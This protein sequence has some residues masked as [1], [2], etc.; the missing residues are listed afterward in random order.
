M[1][2]PV[3]L[4]DPRQAMRWPGEKQATD[5][6]GRAPAEFTHSILAARR[7]GGPFFAGPVGAPSAGVAAAVLD[8][9]ASAGN[10]AVAKARQGGPVP[11]EPAMPADTLVARPA[12]DGAGRA[13]AQPGAPASAAGTTQP[14]AGA[15][16][17]SQSPAMAGKGRGSARNAPAKGGGALARPAAATPEAIQQQAVAVAQAIPQPPTPAP[18]NVPASPQRRAAPRRQ[19]QQ[20]LAGPAPV[21]TVKPPHATIEDPIPDA[22]KQ[23]ETAANAMLPEQVLPAVDASPGGHMPDLVSTPLSFEK[24]RMV[25]LGEQAMNDA[26]LD[27]KEKAELLAIRDKIIAPPK[28][29][30][31]PAAP[32]IPP[33][34]K[35]ASDPLPPSEPTLAERDMFTAVLARLLADPA[36]QA[37]DILDAAKTDLPDYPGTVLLA[38]KDFPALAKLGEVQLPTIE[39][40]LTGAVQPLAQLLGVAGQTLDTAVTARRQLLTEAQKQGVDAAQLSAEQATAAAAANAAAR[41]ADA[42]AAKTVAKDAE[43]RAKDAKHAPKPGFRALAEAAVARIQ[44]K[45]GEGIARIQLQEKE[46]K[47][48]LDRACNRQIAAY[49]AAAMADELAATQANAADATSSN[50]DTARAAKNRTSRAISAA[51]KWAA[52]RIEPLKLRIDQLKVDARAEAAKMITAVQDQGAAAYRALHAWGDAQDG[53]AQS[54][55]QDNARNLDTWANAARDTATTWASAQAHLA[56]LELQRDLQRVRE[57]VNDKMAADAQHGEQYQALTEDRRRD[58]VEQVITDPQQQDSVLGGLAAGFA[59]RLTEAERAPLKPVIDSELSALPIG[60]WAAR[61]Y[62]AKAR[63]PGFNAAEKSDAIY[64]AGAG[65]WGTDNDIIFANLKGLSKLELAAVEGHYQAN[66]KTTLTEAMGSELSGDHKERAL[67]LLQGKGGEAAAEAIHD[68]VW[69]PGT[70]EAQIM[71]ALRGLSKEERDAA[72]RYY[73]EK[74]KESLSA[75]LDEDLGDAQALQAQAL[76]AGKTDEADA[77]ALDDAFRFGWGEADTADVSKVYDQVRAEVMA[78]AEGKGWTAAE[79]EA[80]VLRRNEEIESAFNDKLGNVRQYSN[81]RKRS[82]FANAVSSS[83]HTPQERNF[84]KTLAANDLAS[85]DAARMEIERQGGYADDA[86]L[87]GVI[88]TQMDRAMQATRLDRGPQLAAGVSRQ[89]KREMD[90]DRAAGR[91]WTEEQRLD[92]QAELERKNNETIQ[93]EAFDRA[94]HSSVVLDSALKHDYGTNLASMIADNMSGGDKRE[95]QAKLDLIQKDVKGDDAKA[96]R[97]LDWAY[98]RIRYSIEGAGTDMPQLKAG[99]NGLTK[100]DIDKIN[101]RWKRDHHDETLE[102]AVEGDTSGREEGDLVDTVR[103]G[104]AETVSQKIN[105]LKRKKQRDDA[106]STFIGRW[107]SDDARAR[108][109]ADLAQLEDML[110]DLRDPNLPESRRAHIGA[111][112]NQRVEDA[113]R[114]IEAE[115]AAID[116]LADKA[117]T[118]FQYV[119]GALAVVAA[120][121]VG[122]VSGGT[123]VPALIAIAGSLIGTLGS[124]AIKGA[125]KGG[126]YGTEE[127]ATDLAVGAVDLVVT[128]ITAGAFKGGGFLKGLTTQLK[129]ISQVSFKLAL[130]QGAKRAVGMTV[131]DTVKQQAERKATSLAA[132]AARGAGKFAL[133][134]AEQLVQSLPAGLAAQ[135][136]D[137]RNM[138]EGNPLNNVG[139]GLLHASLE[140]LKMGV[141]MGAFGHAVGMGVTHG[142]TVAHPQRTP[143]EAQLHAYERWRTENP[144]KPRADYVAEMEANQAR[145]AHDQ[146]SAKAATR[147]A[148]KAL[149]DKLPANERAGMSDVP[150]VHLSDAQFKALAAGRGGD[151]FIHTYDGQAAVVVREGA[152]PSAIGELAGKL[153]ETVAPGTA[154]RTVSPNDSLPSHLRNRITFE[155]TKNPD[156]AADGVSAK[157]VFHPDGH[158]I[159]ITVE[160]GPNARA[161]DIQKHVGT[162]EAMHKYMGLLGEARIAANKAANR[163]GID[164]NSPLVRGRW[165]ASLEVAKLPAIIEERI[166][167]LGKEGL[168]PRRQ[169]EV[170][171]QIETLQ[172]QLE[173]EKARLA[174]GA[175]AEARGYVAAASGKKNRAAAAVGAVAADGIVTPATTKKKKSTVKKDLPTLDPVLAQHRADAVAI[176]NSLAPHE[177]HYKSLNE[178]LAGLAARVE[179]AGVKVQDL[180]DPVN[181]KERPGPAYDAARALLDEGEHGA[182]MAL[183]SE[184]VKG[185][186][187]PGS[188][189]AKLQAAV[190]NYNLAIE[191]HARNAPALITALE[192]WTKA[193][194]K[195]AAN[196]YYRDRARW[197][198]SLEHKSLGK[199]GA[200]ICFAPHTPVLCERGLIAIGEI[201]PGEAVWSFDPETGAAVLGTVTGL[202]RGWAPHMMEITTSDGAALLATRGHPFFDPESRRWVPARLLVP[203]ARLLRR[204]GATAKV[205]AAILR[206]G[207][208]E[209]CNLTIEPHHCYFAGASP[210]LV[211]NG[212]DDDRPPKFENK[213]KRD[214]K[215]YVVRDKKTKQIIYVGKTYDPWEVRWRAHCNNPD[216]GWSNETH[217]MIIIKEAQMTDFEIAV[218]EEHFIKKYGGLKKNNPSSPLINDRHEITEKKY[219]KFRDPKYGHNPCLA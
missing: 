191:S 163:L 123:A 80:E 2:P 6:D 79:A 50:A 194:E 96:E 206:E 29:E 120:V 183:L 117:T 77:Y 119:V 14:Q 59:A 52:E 85:A 199:P 41:T 197:F 68:A 154:G 36:K 198:A 211:H 69:G 47:T 157:P 136:L 138:R 124:M 208:S 121:V 146:A 74:Y 127:I 131:A 103:Y 192:P 72:I 11:A 215:L 38:N 106:D 61:Q 203:G 165:E 209:T 212:E 181:P 63:N 17:G 143:V 213:E 128:A 184:R 1:P 144:G 16:E 188:F 151:A 135:L 35:V 134:Q 171:E 195:L 168:D 145:E 190:A 207:D 185:D 4:A 116:S 15:P 7:G 43:Q 210:C 67:L 30:A 33:P 102:A 142:L 158:I 28:E 112:F 9:Q 110:P 95:A 125:V 64:R 18:G 10:Q 19:V 216:K 45:V 34:I 109:E 81:N 137:E 53:A 76:L 27:P 5:P 167:R 140:N 187:T 88:Q 139:K 24:R 172:R 111:V 44:D 202:L 130:G 84:V 178:R 70:N 173:T 204:D 176:L 91:P 133:G 94:R 153:R 166:S 62:V 26:Q 129:H 98:T 60:E 100:A 21:P 104:A 156:F 89:I 108:T 54:W 58:F 51:K 149:L 162:I 118:V 205:A 87:K 86:V 93:D 189:K 114:S 92:R 126:A 150:I 152:P 32:A 56:R 107:T 13:A 182:A 90:F 65:K 31:A 8:V 3:A 55:W 217:E 115:R 78:K 175:A 49:E 113:H 97:R 196:P 180:L 40:H 132:S 105:A 141:G 179:E 201:L 170:L 160:I 164:T 214:G 39:S 12:P 42:H 159:G 20:Q 46:R 101:E 161:V 57:S 177:A 218:W 82:A 219:R 23:I 48:A 83:F 25:L 66:Y 37:H 73:K 169:A 200:L 147:E 99:F 75:R 122:V 155:P 148:R 71:E 22:T 193:Q 186:A 174:L